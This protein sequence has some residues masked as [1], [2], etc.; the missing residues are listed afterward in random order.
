MPKRYCL[1]LLLCIG[2]SVPEEKPVV[3]ISRP[4][5]AATAA[6]HQPNGITADLLAGKVADNFLHPSQFNMPRLDTFRIGQ[7]DKLVQLTS[8][9]ERQYLQQPT[10]HS[11]YKPFYFY[12]IQENTPARKA[13]TLLSYDGEYKHDL[14]RLVYNAQ[15]Q[16]VSK[17]LVAFAA[18]DGEVRDEAY[19]WFESPTRFRFVE[20]QKQPIRETQ[21]TIEYAV[22]SAVTSYQVGNEQFRRLQ[23]HKFQRHTVEI[24]APQ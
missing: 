20:V 9:E 24:Q 11:I 7:T 18:S 17:Q 13:I 21:D 1:A 4:P 23:Q 6:N 16:L 3:V 12:S 8:G 19:G 14:L 10:E 22:D 15:N 2:C 5:E